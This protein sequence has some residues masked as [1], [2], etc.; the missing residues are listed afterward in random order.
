[1][2]LT[3]FQRTNQP[4]P[5]ES[6]VPCPFR[7][8][9]PMVLRDVLSP[10]WDWFMPSALDLP[11]GLWEPLGNYCNVLPFASCMENRTRTTVTV[12][13]GW[14]T[15]NR[16]SEAR[17]LVW[18]MESFMWQ[19]MAHWPLY[20]S[21]VLYAIWGLS[22][23]ALSWNPGKK[24]KENYEK[25]RTDGRGTRG[26]ESGMET[27]RGRQTQTKTDTKRQIESQG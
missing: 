19:T 20:I 26:K 6:L 18:K 12:C 3:S 23:P 25:F 8:S 13:I 1:M 21:L 2:D 5:L 9:G 16:V 27:G 22:A 14:L 17:G 4:S 24:G 7:I 15:R 11:Y 10:D